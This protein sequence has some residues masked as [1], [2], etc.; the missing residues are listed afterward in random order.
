MENTTI[1]K[2]EMVEVD[3]KLLEKLISE[4]NELKQTV[5]YSTDIILLFIDM[6][7]GKLPETKTQAALLITKIP[8]I[9]EK[10]ADEKKRAYINEALTKIIQTAPNY[11]T[12]EQVH[13]LEKMKLLQLPENGN[14]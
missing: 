9:V 1:E 2:K 14:D 4:R 5:I 13:Q 12:A 7:G 8:S 11:I 3:K 6:I 10:F